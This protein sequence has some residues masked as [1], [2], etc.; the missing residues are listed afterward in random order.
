[1]SLHVNKLCQ[2]ASYALRAIGQIRK[3]LDRSSAEKLVHAFVTSRLDYCN[4]LLYGLP[5]KLINKL[6]RIQNSAA[7]LITGAK[8]RDHISHVLREL[9]WLPIKKRII[10]KVLLLVYKSLNGSGPN[11][12]SELLKP[13]TPKV[14]LRSSTQNLLIIPKSNLKSFGDRSFSC[15]GPLLWNALPAHLRL[16]TSVQEFKTGLKTHLFNLDI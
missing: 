2:T 8:K 10:F 9:H 5:D 6:Q 4:S 11:Y 1:M 7:R 13:Y 12:M 15:A 16:A 14:H 3:Y